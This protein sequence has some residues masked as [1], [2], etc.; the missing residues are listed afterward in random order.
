MPRPTLA[1]SADFLD[2]SFGNT[3]KGTDYADYVVCATCKQSLIAARVPSAS[4][5]RQGEPE[6]KISQ[7][8]EGSVHEQRLTARSLPCGAF[9]RLEKSTD[10]LAKDNEALHAHMTDDEV[11]ADMGSMLE[12]EDRTTESVG[13]LQHHI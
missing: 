3:C 5:N 13:L 6:R 10:E 2:R 4:R 11:L 9:Q 1:S 7:M 12:Y 8:K